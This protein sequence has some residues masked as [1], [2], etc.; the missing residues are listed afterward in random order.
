MSWKIREGYG[1]RRQAMEQDRLTNVPWGA[2]TSHLT[3]HA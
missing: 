3:P 1:V 2:I